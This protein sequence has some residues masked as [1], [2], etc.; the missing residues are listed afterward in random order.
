MGTVFTED[1]SM[2]GGIDMSEATG[3][4]LPSG[5]V[6]NANVASSAAIT[7]AKLASTVKSFPIPWSAWRVWDAYQT[8]L[9]GTSASDDLGLYGGTFASASPMI[10]SY[11]LKT[12]S[13]SLYARAM[14]A[15]PSQYDA[16]Q[17]VTIRAK[18]G[19]ITTVA[20]TSCVID[21]EAYK[22]DNFGGI[23]SDLVTTA[24]TTIN[25][26]TQAN[27][28]F[29]VTPASLAIGSILD[30]RMTVTVVDAA[31]ATAVIAGIGAVEMLV[32]CRG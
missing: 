6:L 3:L 14:F 23:G 8:T 18:A 5:V 21:F 28:D 17:A 29:T 7:A 1:V 19:M 32:T 4:T 2:R 16:A 22:S 11:D 13:T 25:S 30:I 9:P 26:L 31:T 27:K 12:L 24:A 20:G 15:L 10:K